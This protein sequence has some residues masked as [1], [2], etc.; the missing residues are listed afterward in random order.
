MFDKVARRFLGS[1]DPGNVVE[2]YA[3]KAIR[4]TLVLCSS[5]FCSLC[6]C[7]VAGFVPIEHGE[8]RQTAKKHHKREW[9][10]ILGLT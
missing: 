8:G 3:M 10:R 9:R 1:Q 7:M 4:E 5:L 6:T 2:E